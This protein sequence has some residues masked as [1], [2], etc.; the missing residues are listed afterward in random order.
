MAHDNAAVAGRRR[1]VKP[2][3]APWARL[4]RYLS[5][6]EVQTAYAFLAIPMLLLLLIKVYPVVYNLYLS[7]TTYELAGP[8]RWVGLKNYAWVLTARVNQRA[9]VNTILYAV[10]AVPLGTALALLVAVLLNRPLRGRLLYRV[11]YY[12]PVVT[13]AVV[14]AMVWRLIYNPQSGLLNALLGAIG[15]PAQKFL[16]SEQQALPCLIVVMIWGALGYNMVIYLAGLQDIPPELYEAARIDGASDVQYFWHVT[17]PLLNPVTLFIV[18]SSAVGVFRSFSIVYMMTQG[19]PNYATT[20]LV[21]EVYTNA[22]SFLRF[23]RAAAISITL[24]VIVLAIS[25]LQFRLIRMED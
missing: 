1:W 17:L 10:G 21:W 22:F 12:L 8:P 13:S 6:Q 4:R 11:L 20:N 19:G 25:L 2:T 18:V 7:F 3:P 16:S 24:L 9:L 5:R 14:V 15:L 23:G